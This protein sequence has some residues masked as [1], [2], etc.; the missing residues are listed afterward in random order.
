MIAG[1]SKK[2]TFTRSS[3]NRYMYQPNHSF[4]REESVSGHSHDPGAGGSCWARRTNAHILRRLVTSDSTDILVFG[5]AAKL[6]MMLTVRLS[7]QI[8]MVI[9][10]VEYELRTKDL[11]ARAASGRNRLFLL[12]L[13]FFRPFLCDAFSSSSS[14]LLYRV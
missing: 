6:E 9:W 8:A 7:F 5:L 12:I 10:T 4:L 14:V 13:A 3:Y 2:V 11:S 1:S